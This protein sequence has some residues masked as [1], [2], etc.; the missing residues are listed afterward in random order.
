[1][2]KKNKGHAQHELF[3]EIPDIPKKVVEVV[4][5]D[6]VESYGPIDDIHNYA[7]EKQEAPKR[8]IVAAQKTTLF[9]A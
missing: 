9:D 6:V 5:L 7:S 8:R 2:N 4:Q 1:M 3:G